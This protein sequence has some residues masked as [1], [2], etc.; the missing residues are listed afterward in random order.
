MISFITGSHAYGT[1]T[2]ESD[3]D[4]VVCVDNHADFDKLSDS[5]NKINNYG[6]VMYGKLNLILFDLSVPGE[7][8][9]YDRWV[10]VHNMLMAMKPVSREQAVELHRQYKT[11]M[12]DKDQFELTN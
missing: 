3:I 12:W 2:A 8:E 10:L 9:R 5:P 4:L 7:K 1:P 6:A 11:S